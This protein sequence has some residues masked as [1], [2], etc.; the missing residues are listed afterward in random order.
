MIELTN[1]K[2]SDRAEQLLERYSDD[3][4]STNLGDFLADAMH[5]CRLKGCDFASILGSA[6][7]HF[8]REVCEQEGVEP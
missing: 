8:E 3:D 5:W 1:S 6:Q 7:M 2:R 4:A